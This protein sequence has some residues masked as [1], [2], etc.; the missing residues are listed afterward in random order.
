MNIISILSI[1]FKDRFAK[2]AKENE[3]ALTSEDKDAK[4]KRVPPASLVSSTGNEWK[5]L[6]VEVKSQYEERYDIA[7][8]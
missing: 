7:C 6:T 5:T 2:L 4:L 8:C 3:H 1:S